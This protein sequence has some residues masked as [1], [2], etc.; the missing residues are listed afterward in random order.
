[1]GLWQRLHSTHRTTMVT[2]EPRVFL[3]LYLALQ[4]LPPQAVPW[5]TGGPLTLAGLLR[6]CVNLGSHTT[7]PC[8][9]RK[10]ELWKR[11][12]GLPW[13]PRGLTQFFCLL[14]GRQFCLA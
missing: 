8:L 2:A 14:C 4:S 12:D 9:L 3:V 13:A 11:C 5:K 10:P 6:S 7:A 1:M